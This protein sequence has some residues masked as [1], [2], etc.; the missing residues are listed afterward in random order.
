[1]RH[2]PTIAGVVLGL[3]FVA[4][5]CIYFF[6]LVNMPPP[7]E[8]SPAALFMGALYPTGYLDFVKA[9]ELIGG[10]LVAIPFTRRIG[11]LILGPIIVN[12]L[13]FHGFITKGAGLFDPPIVVIVALAL[14]LV[15]AD[16]R[17][18]G[19]YI[20]GPKTPNAA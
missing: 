2:L 16:R 1:M 17:A 15:W 13:A 8:G 20:R 9:L 19:S 14:Y 7:P 12:I 5:S 18:F 10:I 11:L 6:K 4:F 3:A